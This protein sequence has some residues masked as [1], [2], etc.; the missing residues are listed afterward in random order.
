MPRYA[1]SCFK[2]NCLRVDI[3]SKVNNNSVWDKGKI[4]FFC[5][6]ALC[7]GKCT[8]T[9]FKT[10]KMLKNDVFAAFLGV[11]CENFIVF[12]RISFTF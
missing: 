11:F 8:P 1:F 2:D 5:T 7:I 3:F 4:Y 6:C 9:G 10:C 12:C